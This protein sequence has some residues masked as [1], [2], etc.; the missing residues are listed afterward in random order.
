MECAPRSRRSSSSPRRGQRFRRGAA[1]AARRSRVAQALFERA[2]GPDPTLIDDVLDLELG[3]ELAL[4]AAVECVVRCAGLALLRG[5]ELGTESSESLL[6]AALEL[7]VARNLQKLAPR[8]EHRA[9][10]EGSSV[11]PVGQA[12]LSDGAYQLALLALSEEVPDRRRRS[13]ARLERE[14]STP[15]D[16]TPSSRR[17]PAG[18]SSMSRGV[19]RASAEGSHST[20][21]IRSAPARV[22]RSAE[23]KQLTWEIWSTA[24]STAFGRAALL[25]E[26]DGEPA[27][28]EAILDA[29]WAAWLDADRPEISVLD[30]RLAAL[31]WSHA[32]LDALEYLA[33][34]GRDQAGFEHLNREQWRARSR[35]AW[36]ALDARRNRSLSG[37]SPPSPSSMSC[38]STAS[39]LEPRGAGLALAASPGAGL[40]A[41]LEARFEPGSRRPT[42]APRFGSSRALTAETARKLAADERL[43]RHSSERLLELGGWLHERVAERSLGWRDAYARLAELERRL[44]T[45][46]V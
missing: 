17:S 3:D 29:V 20:L 44:A 43:A 46:R 10:S 34:K 11:A 40:G 24:V 41:A 30:A 31:L 8:I 13:R 6:D 39:T 23:S 35:V 36:C 42:R 32:P 16:W 25:G 38:S 18:P 19:R 21:S 2:L 7:A 27:K 22:L 28:A 33:W 9:R 37:A 4:A 1:P 26:L 15:S 5:V 45:A 12:L 14:S